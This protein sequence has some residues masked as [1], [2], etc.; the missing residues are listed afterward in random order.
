MENYK[1]NPDNKNEYNKINENT[2][3][4]K[5]LEEKLKDGLITEEEYNNIQNLKREALYESKT[6]KQVIELARNIFNKIKDTLSE[7]DKLVLDSINKEVE[8][9]KTQY[10]KQN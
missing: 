8:E 1:Y 7:E 3:I 6:D 10:P 9:I 2:Y 4:E 5:T